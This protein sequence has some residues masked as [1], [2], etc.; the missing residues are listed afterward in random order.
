MQ[1][2]SEH[3]EHVKSFFRIVSIVALYGIGSVLG[4]SVAG[5]LGFGFNGQILLV[6]VILLTF[7]VAVIINNYLKREENPPST[8]ND[9]NPVATKDYPEL[10]SHAEEVVQWLKNTKLGLKPSEKVVY[11]LPW[12]L[13]LGSTSSG[14]TSLILNAGLDIQALPSQQSLGQNLFRPTNSCDWY[15]SDTAVFID[16]AG[17]YLSEGTDHDEWLALLAT[18]KKYRPERPIDGIIVTVETTNVIKASDNEIEQQ[19]KSLRARID[20]LKT[21]FNSPLP[22]YLVFTHADLISGF[23]VFFSNFDKKDRKQIWGTTIPLE[24]RERA[25]TLFDKEFDYLY[26]ALMQN[27]L[28]HL[29][30]STNSKE[31]LEIFDFPLR[32]ASI[33]NKIGLFV[34]A[35][36]RPSP[37]TD[38]PWL[39]GFYFT[40]ASVI[41]KQ[42]SQNLAITAQEYK[43]KYFIAELI[44]EQLINDSNLAAA[45]M[46]KKDTPQLKRKILVGAIALLSIVLVLGFTTSLFRNRSLIGENLEKG[47]RVDEIIRLQSTQPANNEDSAAIRVEL[48]AME[49]L[50][51]QLILLENYQKSRPLS[52]SYGLYSGNAIKPNLR[53]IYF[54]LLNQ[55]FFQQTAI[56]LESDLR[57]FALND[58]KDRI[59]EEELGRYY[60]LLKIY[61]MLSDPSKTEPT[62]LANRLG[63]Y[64]KKS[65]PTDLELLAQQQLDFYAKQASYDDAPHLKA[66]DKIVAAARQHLTTYPAI[67]RFFKRVTS[68]I[69]I[70]VSPITV[71]SITQ[72]R[73]RGWLV[74][75][76]SVSGSFTIEGYQSYM[77][78]ALASAAEEMSKEDWVM[79]A[80]TVTTKDLSSDVGKLEGIYFHEYATQWQ[81]FLKGLNVPTFKTKEDAIEALKVLSASDSPLA[82]S[83]AEVARQTN[84]TGAKERLS[85]WQKIVG[86][87]KIVSSPQI[88]E[89]EKEFLPLR[90]FLGQGEENS[91]VSQYRASLRIVLDS[92]ESATSDQLTQTSKMLLTGKDDIGL[93]KAEL[94]INKLLDNFT[95]AVTR[96]AAF[97]CKKPLGNLRAMLY[98][99]S[100]A[101]IQQNWQEQIYPKAHALEQGFPF[102]ETGSASI[103]DLTRYLNP[104]NG[105]LIQFFNDRLATSFQETEGKL[106]LKESGAFKF[107]QEF[108]DYLNNCKQL[109][110]ALFAQGGQ[111]M[112]VGYEL[113]LQPVANADV[114]IEIDGTRAETRGTTAQSAKFIW[115]AKSGASGAKI[116]VIQGSKIAE[117]AF[118]GEWGLF[119][120]VAG[121]TTN[122]E[123]NLFILSW[124]IDGTIVR[125]ALRPSSATN[126][127]SRRLF[128]QWHAPKNLQN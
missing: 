48:E 109:R 108:T 40:A 125:A 30:L 113:L 6:V 94:T 118:P 13:L 42:P 22:I 43:E 17:R 100:Y 38:N 122:S 71:E 3:I 92:L 105:I 29:A 45:M 99:S 89:L 47:L 67:N 12:F 9:T 102:T 121:A 72:G 77:Q 56:N 73:S 96:D 32:F 26:E 25:H 68:E 33:R 23:E 50:R 61:L 1:Q 70:K 84:F 36:F 55:R 106:Q 64:W 35:L 8:S 44:Q 37:F 54:D 41:K 28:T 16:T 74:G 75:K 112:E 123:G 46:K 14:K 107:T 120:M 57:T 98:G 49:A 34:S 111:Q 117:K 53:A 69:D 93:Q 58:S 78:K 110:E 51:Q 128:T 10:T 59:S 2:F 21:Q 76:Y 90:Q 126:P 81:Q 85:W 7:P 20:E 82:L 15:V 79:G 66:D 11:Q 95:S 24:Q 104:A 97:A 87:K 27:R 103:T 119:K 124:N 83:L 116:T 4:W 101:Q 88:I 65:Y 62:F 60:D 127:F 91:P 80:S 63:E 52:Y 115:P 31:Q 39:R 19:A 114:V 5:S 86:T 18:I